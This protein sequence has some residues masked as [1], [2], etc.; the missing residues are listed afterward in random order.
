MYTGFVYVVLFGVLVGID[1]MVVLV[2]KYMEIVEVE[3]EVC[4]I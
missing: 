4:E 3:E 2:V 1:D